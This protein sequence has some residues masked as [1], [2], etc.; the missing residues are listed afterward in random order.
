VARVL[1]TG[2]AGFLGSALT[3]RLVADGHIVGVL[4]DFS[5]GRSDRLPDNCEIFEADIRDTQKVRWAI[6]R[7][8]IV[9][10][11]AYVQGTQVFTED[12]QLTIEVALKG[13]MNVLDGCMTH[14]ESRELIVVSSSEA[15]Q[16]PPEGM[17]PTDET[18]PLSV[19][20]VLNPRYAYGGGKIASEIAALSY[21]NALKRVVIARPHNIY[22]PD[23]GAEHVIPQLAERVQHLSDRK[24][25]IQGTGLETRSFCYID[26]TV[27]AL[28]L[29]LEKGEHC[30][31]YHVGND[32][33]LEIGELARKIARFY[34]VEVEVVPGALPKGSPPRRCPDIS[35]IR[36]LGYEPKMPFDEGLA[37]TLSWYALNGAAVE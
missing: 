16:T 24:L 20:D 1:I 4:D 5:R 9:F 23:A 21:A 34:G 29:V 31:V 27:E 26:D 10:H 18:V 12:P 22:G 15:Y 35:R 3:R 19:P 36:A 11:L 37:E 2:G 8:D 7:Y 32:E 14:N 33:E 17:T 25:H 6:M 28:A 30:N 13:I